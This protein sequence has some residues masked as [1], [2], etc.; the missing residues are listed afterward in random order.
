MGLDLHKPAWE[1]VLSVEDTSNRR[2]CA[3]TFFT[4]A[5]SA[6][7]IRLEKKALVIFQRL[8]RLQ[9]EQ[10][11][12]RKFR[13]LS[14][15][16]K[17]LK[18]RILVGP[19]RFELGTSCTPSRRLHSTGP[20]ATGA[21]YTLHGF[22]SSASAP[23]SWPANHFSAQFLAHLCTHAFQAGAPLPRINFTVLRVTVDKRP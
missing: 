3:R 11:V 21:F 15:F 18:M 12:R 10:V 14:K 9:P 6:G 17:W 23:C 16:V 7:V 2:D 13:H 22:G 4:V 19:P 20:T 1:A 8:D 5:P